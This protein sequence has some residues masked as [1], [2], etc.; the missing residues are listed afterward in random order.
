MARVAVLGTGVMGVGMAHS[1]QRAG[2]SVRVWNRTQDKARPLAD[3]GA[4]V[5]ESAA[6]AVRDVDA[7]VLMLFDTTAVIDVLRNASE[8]APAEAV[9]LQCSTIGVDGAQ[10]VGSVAAELD[11]RILDTPVLG[12]RQP[13]ENG[14]LVVLA[15]GEPALREQVDA[16]L[17]AI[18][19][20]TVWVGAQFGNASAL[21][22]VCNAWVVS[23]N[24]A[25]GQ[26]LAL[27]GALGLDPRAFLDAISGGP[28][29]TPYA[30]AKGRL[31]L[32]RD[33]PVSFA[34]DGVRKDLDL[35]RTAMSAKDVPTV[36]ADALQQVYDAAA[37]GGH[38]ADD[39]AAVST[40]FERD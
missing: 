17:D 22:L 11:V 18:G 15:A 39:M 40:F 21:K 27:A 31:M 13:A 36:I 33:F 4:E 23:L 10:Q 37:D 14:E 26:S 5:C 38:G 19:S 29:D 9:W 28:V 25:L 35:I 20:R 16:V 2:H 8:A 12:T 24:A 6:D 34:L 3:D 30:H 7:V 32:E 1:L